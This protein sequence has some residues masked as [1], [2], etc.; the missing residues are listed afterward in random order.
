M[1]ASGTL[2]YMIFFLN[3]V[4]HNIR[5]LKDL[6][7]KWLSRHRRVNDGR[8]FYWLGLPFTSLQHWGTDLSSYD[9]LTG[10][11]LVWERL[12]LC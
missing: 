12:R 7:L 1:K 5:P 10:M 11:F 9:A 4:F 6:L 3:V 8:V 2:P